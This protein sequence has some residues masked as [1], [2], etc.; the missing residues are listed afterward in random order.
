TWLAGHLGSAASASGLR[1]RLG[2]VTVILTQGENGA[3]VAAPAET[4]HQPAAR[5]TPVDT[6]AAGDC[7]VGV[8][9]SRLD[10]GV[11]VRHAVAVASRAAALCCT[12]AGSQGSLPERAE[13][14]AFTG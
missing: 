4:W 14:E 13:T 3:E 11:S 6:T 5:I 2:G 10:A 12:R 8:L 9:A 7:F 1:D